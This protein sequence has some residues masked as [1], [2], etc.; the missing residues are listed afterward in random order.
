MGSVSFVGHKTSVLTRIKYH[1]TEVLYSLQ[2]FCPL[3]KS[4]FNLQTM[5]RADELCT[6][7]IGAKSR[8][9]LALS[10][11]EALHPKA[12]KLIE[13]YYI[14][15]GRIIPILEDIF[16]PFLHLSQRF[17]ETEKAL[18]EKAKKVFR[19]FKSKTKC[20]FSKLKVEMISSM[21]LH[22]LHF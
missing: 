6:Y 16:P 1:S 17:R 13:Y 5:A 8:L 3:Q 22:R 4:Y 10:Y 2:D 14:V 20:I 19:I 18:A 9:L 12:I 11:L 7:L 15:R 21:L